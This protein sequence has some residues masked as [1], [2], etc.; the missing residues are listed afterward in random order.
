MSSIMLRSTPPTPALRIGNRG[1]PVSLPARPGRPVTTVTR[2]PSTQPERLAC[3]GGGALVLHARIK[4]IS[5]TVAE[6][7]EAEHGNEDGHARAEGRPGGKAHKAPPGAQ[8][9]APAWFRR[10]C[11]EPEEGEAGFREDGV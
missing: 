10:L 4:D 7:V 2:T 11:A 5:Q 8:H 6:D 9:R 1:I 3:A